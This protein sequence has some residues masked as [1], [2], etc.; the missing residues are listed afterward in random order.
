[1]WILDGEEIV[2]NP[3]DTF[4]T[5]A[6]TRFDEVGQVTIEFGVRYDGRLLVDGEV[7]SVLDGTSV[8]FGDVNF[9]GDLIF[10]SLDTAVINI[11]SVPEPAAFLLLTPGLFYLVRRERRRRKN[12]PSK[13]K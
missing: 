2:F 1:M 11:L 9:P 10:T 12:A 13:E 5:G 8:N 3:G 7:V 4:Q 6:G